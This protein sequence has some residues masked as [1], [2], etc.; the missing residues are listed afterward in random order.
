M[1]GELPKFISPAEAAERLGVKT[2][3][4]KAWIK[5][6]KIRHYSIGGGLNKLSEQDVIAFVQ[7]RPVTMKRKTQ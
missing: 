3:T 4:V 1:S 6:G 7:E 2:G 5:L